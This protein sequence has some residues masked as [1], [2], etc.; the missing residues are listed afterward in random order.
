LYWLVP[1]RVVNAICTDPDALLAPGVA[2]VTVISST[3]SRRG[4]TIEKNPSP[5]CSALPVLI[6]SIVMLMVLFGRPLMTA[7][8]GP[9]AV[10]TPGRNATEY[11]ELREMSGSCL[12][13]STAIVDVTAVDWVCTSV[14]AALTSTVSFSAPTSSFTVMLAGVAVTMRMSLTTAVLNPDRETVAL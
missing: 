2:P 11:S 13:C 5:D 3:A 7:P 10:S 1:E 6:P 9:P 14:D 12:S 8:R 4:V